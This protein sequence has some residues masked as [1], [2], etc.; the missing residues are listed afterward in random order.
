MVRYIHIHTYNRY[1][2]VFI[3]HDAQTFT[4]QHKKDPRITTHKSVI[5]LNSEYP[6]DVSY[7]TNIVEYLQRFSIVFRCSQVIKQRMQCFQI[8]LIFNSSNNVTSSEVFRSGLNVDC[9]LCRIVSSALL[10]GDTCR[11]DDGQAQNLIENFQQ[12]N[13]KIAAYWNVSQSITGNW[14]HGRTVQCTVSHILRVDISAPCK[15]ARW[16]ICTIQET[17]RFLNF[18]NALGL[19]S[20]ALKP[21]KNSNGLSKT[22][23]NL[24]GPQK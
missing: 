23:Q 24:V 9:G 22:R 20:D 14:Y 19:K 10:V 7:N 21:N 15:C 13:S 2:Q 18:H 1:Q 8:I 12:E 6:A 3:Q 5:T 4:F 11:P 17:V 16:R